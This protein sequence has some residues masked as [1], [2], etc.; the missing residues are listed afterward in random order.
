MLIKPCYLLL[1]INLSVSMI[2]WS[3]TCSVSFRLS[4]FQLASL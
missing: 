1:K 3:V 4:R 2:T